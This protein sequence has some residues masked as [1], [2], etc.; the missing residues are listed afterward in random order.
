M[1]LRYEN[2]DL[3]NLD[4][5]A[6][7]DV[8]AV[9]GK[10][11]VDSVGLFVGYSTL[12]SR[13]FPTRGERF[14]V[15]YEEIGWLGGDYDFHRATFEWS[16]YI[17][18]DEDFLGQKSVL[19]FKIDT[20]LNFGTHPDAPTFERFYAGG[21]RSFRGFD[22]RGV[23]PRGIR[24]DTGT[25]SDDPVGGDFM[26]LFGVEYNYPLVG[27]QIRGV[28]FIDTGTVNPNASMDNYR[29]SVGGGIRL[30]L[31]FTGQAPFAFDLSVPIVQEDTDEERLFSFDL[32]LPF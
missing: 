10:S 18:V 22:F 23:G 16:R 2:V 6:P 17:T 19:S 27:D 29:V 11:T 20:G 26:F 1:S 25:L 4:P 9:Q 32:A 15:G 8:F 14:K 3:S 31:P 12:D 5:T 30:K 24:N 7:V 13:F 28:F 21:H